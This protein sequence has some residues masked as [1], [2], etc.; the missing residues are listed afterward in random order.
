M[1][2]HGAAHCPDP[3]RSTPPVPLVAPTAVSQLVELSRSPAEVWAVQCVGAACPFT[4]LFPLSSLFFHVFHHVGLFSARIRVYHL[5]VLP[6]LS[7]LQGVE[8]AGCLTERAGS[9]SLTAAQ[10]EHQQ[11]PP[12]APQGVSYKDSL[13]VGKGYKFRQDE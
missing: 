13:C 11:N 10:Q 1:G 7:Y 9:M 12:A 2:R 3:V 5:L 8:F 6:S 4:P